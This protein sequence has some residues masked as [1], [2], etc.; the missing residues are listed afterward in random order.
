LDGAASQDLVLIDEIGTGTDPQEGAALAMSVLEV[1]TSRGALT[2]VTTHQGTLKAFA[3]ETPGMANGS[4]AF[5]TETLTPTY[6]FRPHLPGSS[7]AFEIAKRM[8]L[9]DTIITRSRSLMGSQAHRLEDLILQLQDQ[10]QRNE[11]LETDLEAQAGIL[12]DLAGRY[13]RKKDI[14]EQET[15]HLRRQAAEEAKDL[16]REANAA[17]EKAIQTV[18]EGQATRQ[19]IH[20]A[21]ALIRQEKETIDREL[22][23]TLPGE[24]LP[25]GDVIRDRVETGDRVHWTR[26]GV[27]AT[28]LSGEDTTGEI[29]IASG[30]LKVRVPKAELTRDKDL[31]GPHS[32]LRSHVNIPSPDKVHTEIDVRGMQVVEALEAVDKFLNDA[33]LGGLREVHIIHGVGTG[34]LRNSVVPFLKGHPLV[35]KTLPGGLNQ[36]NP[37]MTTATITGK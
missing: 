6:K 37:G 4:M 7:Y 14:L 5:D 19:A 22:E 17:V 35:Q 21:K 32:G 30:N 12:E 13:R 27:Y 11:Q 24:K 18:R 8:G 9:T 26:G 1:L 36:K 2:I 10:I 25:Q 29:L 23:A 33:L 16:I 28:V 20:D 34:A 15:K 31:V 3:H